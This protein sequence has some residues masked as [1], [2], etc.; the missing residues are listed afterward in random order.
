[1]T[2]SRL[3]LV[4]GLFI[5]P[6]VLLWLGHRLR[7]Q[8]EARRRVFWGA[9]IGYVLGMLLTLAAIHYPPVLWGD[10]GWRTAAVHWGMLVGA[11]VGMAVGRTLGSRRRESAS[12][13]R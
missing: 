3:A 10:G 4:I 1:M 12:R 2:D 6:A 11:V 13:R 9:T 8:T 7:R 5:V